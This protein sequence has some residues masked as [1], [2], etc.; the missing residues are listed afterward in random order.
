MNFDSH[1]R[2]IGGILSFNIEPKVPVAIREHLVTIQ[3][4]VLLRNGLGQQNDEI[5][6][7]ITKRIGQGPFQVI[8]LGARKTLIKSTDGTQAWVS[9]F[10]LK[11]VCAHA[12]T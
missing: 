2:D 5:V 9:R 6:A 8:R 10:F 1:I 4:S 12:R 7:E 11:P 3:D